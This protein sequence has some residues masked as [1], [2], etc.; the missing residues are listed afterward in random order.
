MSLRKLDISTSLAAGE[1][2]YL[3]DQLPGVEGLGL[4]V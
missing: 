4:K 3:A 2:Y 1:V